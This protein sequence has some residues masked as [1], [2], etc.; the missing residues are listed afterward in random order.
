MYVTEALDLAS[1][2]EGEPIETVGAV[3]STINEVDGP[4]E[5]AVFPAKSLAEAAASEIDAVPSP[6]HD[7]KVTV[8]VAVPAPLT[9]AVQLAVP[10]VWTETSLAAKV[11]VSAPE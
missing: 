10:V 4:A 8:R 6:E 11:T 2:T 3:L 1:V 9:A 7:D 5:S